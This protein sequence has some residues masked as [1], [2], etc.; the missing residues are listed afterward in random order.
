MVYKK[1]QQTV[2]Q[3]WDNIKYFLIWESVIADKYYIFLYSYSTGTLK[4]Y[5]T[6]VFCGWFNSL[7]F[8]YTGLPE[9][10]ILI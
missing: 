9:K 7:I 5:F 1:R 6:N 10:E 4:K 3:C 8:L 2:K